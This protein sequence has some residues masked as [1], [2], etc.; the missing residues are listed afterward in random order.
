MR[1]HFNLAILEPTLGHEQEPVGLV[2]DHILRVYCGDLGVDGFGR[3]H[4]RPC[5]VQY[6]FV[7]SVLVLH[8]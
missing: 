5:G 6:E 7:M 1:N 3:G 2:A 8:D 4:Q